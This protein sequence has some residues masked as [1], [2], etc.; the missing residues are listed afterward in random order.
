MRTHSQP[1]PCLFLDQVLALP[2]VSLL[3]PTRP[4]ECRP[5]AFPEH[6]PTRFRSA[7]SP[8]FGPSAIPR[9][10][11]SSFRIAADDAQTNS[12]TATTRIKSHRRG[13]T[14]ARSLS[15]HHNHVRLLCTMR[16]GQ[17]THTLWA[18]TTLRKQRARTFTNVLVASIQAARMGD[19][20][21]VHQSTTRRR[22]WHTGCAWLAQ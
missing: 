17:L 19:A 1:I 10:V 16:A 21:Y 5:S 22:R 4:A 15:D 6:K 11:P 8:A 13:H 14:S 12:S 3:S 2:S 9:T 7:F 20:Q 18:A